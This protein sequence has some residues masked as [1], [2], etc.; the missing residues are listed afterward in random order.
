MMCMRPS[1]QAARV[2]ELRAYVRGLAGKDWPMS[3][4]GFSVLVIGKIDEL[5]GGVDDGEQE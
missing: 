1:E 2:E 4:E 3:A 5:F